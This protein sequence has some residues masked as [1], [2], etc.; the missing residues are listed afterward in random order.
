M[1]PTSKFLHAEVVNTVALTG[2]LVIFKFSCLSHSSLTVNFSVGGITGD[3][4]KWLLADLTVYT[5]RQQIF[6]LS[7]TIN[8]TL[9]LRDV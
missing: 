9:S 5:V 2:L 8:C 4:V 1:K 6:I 3:K 7:A